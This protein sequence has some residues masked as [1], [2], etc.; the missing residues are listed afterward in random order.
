MMETKILN[1]RATLFINT[2]MIYND[3]TLPDYIQSVAEL[4]LIPSLNKGLGVKIAPDGSVIPEQMI[5]LDLKNIEDSFKVTLGI[6]RFDIVSSLNDNSLDCFLQK[7]KEVIN[8]LT[9]IYSGKYNRLALGSVC[10][11]Y[12]TPEKM[13]LLYNKMVN[14]ESEEQPVE[15]SIRKVIRTAIEN[16]KYRLVINNVY[17]ISRR[18]VIED[19]SNTDSIV[20]EHDINTLVGSD[21]SAIADLSDL[22]IQKASETISESINSYSKYIDS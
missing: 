4:K 2:P 16:E 18:I 5:S 14:T 12:I 10:V 17:T 20:L 15:W 6:D 13:N 22:F 19:G 9:K 11:F 8:A 7:V 3:Q 21:L 1:R